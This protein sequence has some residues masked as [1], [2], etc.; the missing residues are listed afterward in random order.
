MSKKIVLVL[1]AAAL[2]LTLAACGGKVNE[3]K[4]PVFFRC[5]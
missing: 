3:T 4:N 1:L 5:I 2:L